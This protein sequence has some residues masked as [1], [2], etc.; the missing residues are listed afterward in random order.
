MGLYRWGQRDVMVAH[1]S[2][3]FNRQYH[4][5]SN[6]NNPERMEFFYTILHIF[7]TAQQ[8]QFIYTFSSCCYCICEYLFRSF[9]FYIHH[10]M[11]LLLLRSFFISEWRLSGNVFRKLS[12]SRIKLTMF[13]MWHKLFKLEIEK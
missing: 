13:V 2:D 11:F 4:K 9:P 1:Q 3:F 5:Y 10:S 8:I 7:F 6:V 12:K